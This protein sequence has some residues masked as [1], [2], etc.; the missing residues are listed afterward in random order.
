MNRALK[1]GINGVKVGFRAVDF[2]CCKINKSKDWFLLRVAERIPRWIS[3]NLLSVIRI[4]FAGLII[5]ILLYFRYAGR[6]VSWLFLTSVITDL[7]DGP[8]ARA[9][10]KISDTGAF[11]DRLGDKLIICPMVIAL[12]WPY[13]KILVPVLVSSEIISL[14]IAI[15]AI[16]HSIPA[17]SNWLGKWKMAGQSIGI[18]ILLFFPQATEVAVP[19]LWAAVALG[20]ASLW[21]HF[22]EYV[23]WIKK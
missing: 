4:G 17:H 21:S 18:I 12:L 20:A 1:N 6:L 13:D 19:I 23:A 15:G 7:I 9:H 11:L 16:R 5:L 22:M 3:P 14:Y 10:G 2:V 8:I